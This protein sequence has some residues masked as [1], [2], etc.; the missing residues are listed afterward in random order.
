VQQSN[1]YI[2][3]FSAG[4][5]IVLGGLLAFAAQAL[6]PAQD[7]AKALDVKKQILG[8]VVPTKGVDK[9]LLSSQ[10]DERIRSIVINHT[11]E[12]VTVIGSDSI[13]AEK[14][15]VRKESK[16]EHEERLYPV[17]LYYKEGGAKAGK[18]DAYIVP[19]YGK[20]LWNDI[21]GYLALEPDFETVMGISLDHLGETP[22]LG[23]RIT[24]VKVQERYKGKK[25]QV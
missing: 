19:L 24:E 25:H 7:I 8:A 11:G 12:E 14:V 21:W 16:K 1:A 5:T 6:K 22:G 17:Y 3:G 9:Q 20:G 15:D 18:P 4:L 13:I 10:Y 23:A 2:I